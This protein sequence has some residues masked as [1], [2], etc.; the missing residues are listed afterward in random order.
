MG[1]ILV[2]N[3]SF[4]PIG[5]LDFANGSPVDFQESVVDSVTDPLVSLS[6]AWT[7]KRYDPFGGITLNSNSLYWIEVS[8]KPPTMIPLSNVGQPLTSRD[9]ASP[10][11]TPLVVDERWVL[12]E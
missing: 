8:V 12:S 3:L 5:G 4:D 2:A 9:L 7:L 10:A 1:G 6:T 11:T